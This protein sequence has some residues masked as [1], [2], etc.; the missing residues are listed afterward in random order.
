[1]G[2]LLPALPEYEGS[3]LQELHVA[4]EDV[5]F[6]ASPYE[7][8]ARLAVLGEYIYAAAL[9]NVL[10]RYMTPRRLVG[11]AIKVSVL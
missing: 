1:M 4:T 10:M 2:P 11:T 9:A 5:I 8:P 7:D 6:P 3:L